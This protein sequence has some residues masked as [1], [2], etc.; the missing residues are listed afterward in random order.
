MR[1]QY[2]RTGQGFLIVYSVTCRH[3]FHIVSQFRDQI[4][5]VKDADNVPIVL[6]GNK[7]RVPCSVLCAACV[8]ECNAKCWCCTRSLLFFTLFLQCDL[9]DDR[10]VTTEEGRALAKSF[11]VPFFESSAK[12]RINVEEPFYELVRQVMFFVAR[13]PYAQP[14]S[15]ACIADAFRDQVREMRRARGELPKAAAVRSCC[16]LTP[17]HV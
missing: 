9:V 15:R 3:S 13:C 7:V 2:M 4:L 14:V 12:S 8:A 16:I 5:R 17:F 11:G 1:D 10:E 6:V